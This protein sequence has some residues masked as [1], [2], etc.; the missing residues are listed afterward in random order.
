MIICS[1][2]IF[3]L[4][5]ITCKARSIRY[6]LPNVLLYFSLYFSVAFTAHAEKIDRPSIWVT[7][8]DRAKILAKI[9]NEPWAQ[10]LFAELKQRV[11]PLASENIEQRKALVANLPLIWQGASPRKL[12]LPTFKVRGGGSVEQWNSLSKTILDG[13]D[14]GVLFYLT[15]ERKYAMCGADVLYNVVAALKHMPIDKGD[16]S[17]EFQD[18]NNKGWLFPT[19]HLFEARGIGAQLPIIYDFIYPYIASGGQAYDVTSDSV[20]RF[21]VANTQDVFETYIWLALNAGTAKANWT[22]FESA[23]L[24][25]N[26]LALED[27][28]AIKKNLTYFTHV[29]TPRQASLKTVAEAFKNEGDIWPESLQYSRRVEEVSVYLMTLLDRY[30]P[31]LALGKKYPNILAAYQT[32]H[33]LQF[34]NDDFP[35]IGDGERTFEIN[36]PAL[37]ISRLLAKISQNNK[38]LDYYD[39][40]LSASIQAKK[41]DRG[42]LLKRF[43]GGRVY[44]TPLQLL[45]NEEKLSENTSASLS[46]Q[47]NR[48]TRLDY[49][50]MNIQRNT[51]FKNPEK[52]SLMGFV[53]GSPYI[54][55]H[56]SG[57]D[58]EL[59][60]Q[61]Y[62]LGIDGGKGDYTTQIHENYYRLFAAHNTV[63]SNGASASDKRWVNLGIKKVKQEAIEPLPN[64]EA[65]SPNHSFSISSFLDKFNLVDRAEHERTL[66]LIKVSDTQGYY[67]DIFRAKA[68][69]KK[70]R[71][72]YQGEYHDYVYHNIG[73]SIS[74]TSK[75]EPVEVHNDNSRYKDSEDLPWIRN[76][77][78]IHP[79]WHYFEQVKS[80]TLSSRQ[81]EVTFSASKL[82]EQPIYMRAIS[83]EGIELDVTQALAPPSVG[84]APP[85]DKEPLPVFLLRHYGNA[86]QNPFVVLYESST[87]EDSFVIKSVERLMVEREFKGL[88]VEID[89]GKQR[90]TQFILFQRKQDSEYKNEKENIYFKG[91]F[92]V[93]SVDEKTKTGELYIGRGSE[94]KFQSNHLSATKKQKM[95]S[96]RKF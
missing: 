15:Q 10:S 73:D 67:I 52:N 36:Y 39:D 92:A 85:Y 91:R 7:N 42:S 30:D 51:N 88:K 86:W 71:Y 21:D 5:L 31:A 37:E 12:V 76:K 66:A 69:M 49:A 29:D 84:A 19:D 87:G 32:Y 80:S 24:V 35:F 65:V 64:T 83:V 18:S 8:S 13:I 41:Y 44:T 94:L 55:G 82:G 33:Q 47:R 20:T 90:L 2:A 3:S 95:A 25:H 11:E 54:H 60:G 77:R 48:T 17:K 38:Q 57:M 72:V 96:Y 23:S 81:H 1:S 34:P 78:Y 75:D 28:K 45:W 79:G 46:S 50:G 9:Q 61:G 89:T 22:V 70:S 40:F 26:T 14:C 59:Y 6:K 56:A 16:P 93:I 43:Y 74:I 4:S 62:V 68:K 58:M 63:I 27:P 53:A